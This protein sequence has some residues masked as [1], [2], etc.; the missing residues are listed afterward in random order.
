MIATTISSSTSVNPF[1]RLIDS[2]RG[3]KDAVAT[4]YEIKERIKEEFG[5]T[6]NVGVGRN[7][8]LSK[9]A[10]ELEKPDKV[11]T[12]LD[13]KDIYSK[14]WP[15][16]VNEL[17]MVGRA[18]TRKLKKININTIGDLAQADPVLLRTIFKSHGICR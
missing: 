4:A 16:D 1:F 5:F 17:F 7:K 2:M 11:H 15:L 8:L 3:G 13:E 10:C 18:T 12:L 9:M 6:V 14:M